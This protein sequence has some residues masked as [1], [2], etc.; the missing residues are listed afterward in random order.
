MKPEQPPP[1]SLI[2]DGYTIDLTPW[3][4]H[5]IQFFNPFKRR[6]VDKVPMEDVM[7]LIDALVEISAGAPRPS[8]IANKALEEFASKYHMP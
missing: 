8:R 6:R 5:L 4:K 2:S 3:W 1:A 7:P